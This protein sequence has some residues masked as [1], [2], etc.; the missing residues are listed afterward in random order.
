MILALFSIRLK[1]V[2]KI[3]PR[4]L[5]GIKSWWRVLDDH[6]FFEF[7][8]LLPFCA[9]PNSTRSWAAVLLR[10][11]AFTHALTPKMRRPFQSKSPPGIGITPLPLPL[12]RPPSPLF[13]IP[14][15]Y[16]DFNPDDGDCPTVCVRM[17]F[18][19]TKKSKYMHNRKHVHVGGRDV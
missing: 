14:P 10:G 8:T 5:Q 13:C 7:F 17:K 15:P 6:R 9:S 18:S 19:C 4:A 16:T 2:A 12:F 11:G 3:A 1:L